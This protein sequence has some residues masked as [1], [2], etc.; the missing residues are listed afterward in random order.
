MLFPE[1]YTEDDVRCFPSCS[2]QASY[3]YRYVYLYACLHVSGKN[4]K[5]RPDTYWL[6]MLYL[7]LKTTL[8]FDSS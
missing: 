7:L 1:K 5:V 8:Y 3:M 2:F 6:M 4:V